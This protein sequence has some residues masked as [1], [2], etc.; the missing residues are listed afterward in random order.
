M[1]NDMQF[2]K[3]DIIGFTLNKRHIYILTESMTY[4]Y[5]NM[6]TIYTDTLQSSCYF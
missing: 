6:I 1:M 4:V 3:T 5:V 2:L